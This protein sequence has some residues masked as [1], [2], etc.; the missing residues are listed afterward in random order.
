LIEALEAPDLSTP[1]HF[2]HESAAQGVWRRMATGVDKAALLAAQHLIDAFLIPDLERLQLL[3]AS[4]EPLLDDSL[5]RDPARYFAFA[6]SEPTPELTANERLRST[7]RCKRTAWKLSGPYVRFGESD[8][9]PLPS[10]VLVE[11]WEHRKQEPLATGVALHGFVMGSPRAGA[12][13]LSASDWFDRGLDVALVTLPGHGARKPPQAR[14]SGESF[15]IPDVA[16]LAES[17]RQAVYEIRLVQQWL[18]ARG[19]EKVGLLGLSLGGYLAALSAGL[20]DDI[21]FVIPIIAPVC[22]GD[23]AYRFLSRS[24]VARSRGRSGFSLD[25]MRSS[26]WIHSPLAH[27]LRTPR[28]RTLI[29][30]GRGDQ[31]VP[32]SHSFALWRHWNEPAIH[33][34]TGSH[35]APFGRRAAIGAIDQHL[36]RLGI[37]QPGPNEAR[38]QNG[39]S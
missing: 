30:A 3:R 37:L 10:P 12:F 31:I 38:E 19:P 17:V 14:F 35:I 13:A 6:D 7:S 33:W 8:A 20:Y 29:V 23:L 21:D 32:T 25:Q 1:P 34:F 22:M 2:P 11:H 26:F 18:R 15:A 28:E 27:P 9:T 36:R 24:R 4:A 16:D 5:L 39:S